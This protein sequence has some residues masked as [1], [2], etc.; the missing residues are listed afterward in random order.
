VIIVNDYWALDEDNYKSLCN[1][2]QKHGMQVWIHKTL[3]SEND[4]GAGFLIRGG[5]VVST[6][7]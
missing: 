3:R 1:A 4:S 5:E 7:K 2:A 6:P